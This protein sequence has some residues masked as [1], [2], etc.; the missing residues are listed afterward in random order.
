MILGLLVAMNLG[1]ILIAR[2]LGPVAKLLPPE[3][4]EQIRAT[5]GAFWSQSAALPL[6]S[7]LERIFALTLQLALS[8]LV[9]QSV[10]HRRP[11]YFVAALAIHTLADAWIIWGAG[12]GVAGIE[13]GVGLMALVGVW[14]I[15]R[16]REQPA[17]ASP[18]L[19]SGTG[20]SPVPSA[21][22]LTEQ[23]LSPEELARRA[24]RSRYE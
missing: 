10:T 14:I 11:L 3:A 9:V 22:D 4:L 19:E 13:A 8:V 15:W 17:A 23:R 7:V 21:A 1:A 2:D 20:S 18:V 6:V 12:L 16:L 24:E 5:Q